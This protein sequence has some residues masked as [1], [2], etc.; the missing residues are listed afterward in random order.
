MEIKNKYTYKELYTFWLG[1]SEEIENIANSNLDK[2]IKKRLFDKKME[3]IQDIIKYQEIKIEYKAE[4]VEWIHDKFK[5][6]KIKDLF[7]SDNEINIFYSHFMAGIVFDFKSFSNIIYLMEKLIN[8]I[9]EDEGF[10]NF[11]EL[12]DGILKHGDVSKLL[13]FSYRK[14]ADKNEA[15]KIK[16]KKVA[17]RYRAIYFLTYMYMRKKEGGFQIREVLMKNK[18]IDWS[19]INI[20]YFLS[21]NMFFIISLLDIPCISKNKNT[22]DAN[23]RENVDWN[24]KQITQENVKEIIQTPKKFNGEERNLIQYLLRD[25]NH[26]LLLLK[27]YMNSNLP[28]DNK[29]YFLDELGFQDFYEKIENEKLNDMDNIIKVLNS[30]IDNIDLSKSNSDISPYLEDEYGLKYVFKNDEEKNIYMSFYILLHIFKKSAINLTEKDFYKYLENINKNMDE[31]YF[32]LINSAIIN[33]MN[34]NFIFCLTLCPFIKEKSSRISS[35]LNKNQKAK[36]I[37]DFLLK[38]DRLNILGSMRHGNVPT[39]AIELYGFMFFF[40]FVIFLLNEKVR[41]KI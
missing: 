18:V 38:H 32:D 31:K 40:L 36:K 5:N 12:S 39:H 4:D 29:N 37:I 1:T 30:I 25:E 33:G 35:A 19:D 16:V 3:Y 17:E 14:D 2:D 7:L 11:T 41:K 22:K 34:G 10:S 13:D 20:Y 6:S 27:K 9:F 21:L 15:A 28:N 23:K 24:N 8:N 26:N